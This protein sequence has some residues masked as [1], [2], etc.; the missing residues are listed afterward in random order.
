MWRKISYTRTCIDV[1]S[2]TKTMNIKMHLLYL[3]A[4]QPS[5]R[6]KYFRK[7]SLIKTSRL[8]CASGFSS[9]TRYICYIEQKWLF[10]IFK[11]TLFSEQKIR[12][13]ASECGKLAR[14]C[15]EQTTKRFF[16]KPEQLLCTC[17]EKNKTSSCSSLSWIIYASARRVIMNG[18]SPERLFNPEILILPLNY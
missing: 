5:P 8:V 15:F 13:N 4:G 2:G 10:L 12:D 14:A 9:K 6:W 18:R 17:G 11:C 7:G 1:V 3:E 16:T